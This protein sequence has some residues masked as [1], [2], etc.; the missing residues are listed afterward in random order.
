MEVFEAAKR[1][2]QRYS[3]RLRPSLRTGDPTGTAV[4]RHATHT[5]SGG[6]GTATVVARD[7][8]AD[9][10]YSNPMRSTVSSSGPVRRDCSLNSLTLARLSVVIHMRGSS[11]SRPAVRY[12]RGPVSVMA[13]ASSFRDERIA[14]VVLL[15]ERVEEVT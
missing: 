5:T 2:Q 4:F 13:S 3:L 11:P 8:T 10:R 15:K 14:H 7:V 1:R 9:E 12:L 6:W